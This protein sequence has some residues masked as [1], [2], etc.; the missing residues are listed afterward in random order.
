MAEAGH[1]RVHVGWMAAGLAALLLIFISLNAFNL[2]F[3][4][5]RSPGQLFFFTGLSVLVFLLLVGLLVLLFRNILK[6]YADERSRVLGSRIRTRMLVGALLLSFAPAL[7]LFLFSYSLMN[8]TVDRWF[9]QP[10]S[11]LRIES[12]SVALELEEYASANARAEAASCTWRT[13]RC[14]SAR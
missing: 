10:V 11:Q 2:P 1:R 14:C 6:L 8:R 7:F 9:S 13:T 5:P 3:L 4:L 12:N